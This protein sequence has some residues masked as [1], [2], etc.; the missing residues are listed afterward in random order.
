MSRGRMSGRRCARGP[1]IPAGLCLALA[2]RPATA[3]AQTTVVRTDSVP[4][5]V[6]QHISYHYDAVEQSLVRPVTRSLDLSLLARKLS[7]NQR[8]AANVDAADQVRLP[9]TWWQPRLGFRPVS[10]EEML[11]GPGAGTGPAGKWTVTRAKSQGVSKGFRIKDARGVRFSIKFDPVKYPELT[12]SADV[13]VSKLIWAAG[14][15]VPDNSIAFFRREDLVIGADAT[16]DVAGKKV[17]IDEAFMDE[18]LR[19]IPQEPD[20]RYRVVASRILDG[21]PL[22]EWRYSRRRTD[23]PE[24]AIPHELRREIRGLY[25]ICAWTN[26]TDCSARNTIDMYVNDGGRSFV[27][28]YLIDFSG[29]LGSASITAQTPRDGNEYLVNFGSITKSLVTLGLMPFKWEHAVDPGMPSV[30]F[31]DA[32]TFDPGAWRPFIP[33]PAFDVRTEADIRWGARIVAAFSDAHIRA[34]VDAGRY[35]DPRAAEYLRRILGERRD[36]IVQRWLPGTLAES[37]RDRG[38]P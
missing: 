34:A 2:L 12:T 28:H 11:A 17:K 22:G 24:D 20:G 32:D 4:P 16:H 10:P 3:H 36:K 25:A 30:G 29:C 1:W 31:I 23:D 6:E 8:E 19:G 14:Y 5:P 27:R 21:K 33:N 37:G 18:L 38:Q 9:S 26:H 35:S 13:V 15:N 7:K